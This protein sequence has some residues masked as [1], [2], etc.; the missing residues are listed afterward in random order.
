M[1]QTIGDSIAVTLR[2]ASSYHSPDVHFH[3]QRR[4][5]TVAEHAMADRDWKDEID[6][7]IARMPEP[8]LELID[9]RL[10]VGNGLVGSRHLL[11]E[12]LCDYGTE[13]ALALA[14]YDTWLEAMGE[15]F[16]SLT[17]PSFDDLAAVDAWS[18]SL[19]YD[20]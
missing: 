15:A 18:K 4:R 19:A 9:G 20:P 16:A 1:A 14:P 6:R 11:W 5:L 13:A 17:P 12:I 10:I 2:E 3:H 8:K 7:Y